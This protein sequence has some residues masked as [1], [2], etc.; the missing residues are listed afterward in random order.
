MFVVNFKLDFKKML[1]ISV[2]IALIVATLIEFGN[3]PT[4]SV[5]SKIDGYD[6]IL[7]DENYTSVLDDIHNNIDANVGKTVKLSGFV[8]RMPDF[9]ENFIVCGR[10]TISNNEDKIAGFL[11]NYKDASK[12]I[13]N[14]WIEIT[15]VITKGDYNGEMPIIKIGTVEKITAPANTFVN[16]VKENVQST[17]EK[18]EN[19]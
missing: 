11:C 15:G 12:L 4:T 9:K 7:T 18:N 19:S 14:E 8:F 2:F 5:N 13:D 10:N 17:T 16:N 6:F 3:F 1:I